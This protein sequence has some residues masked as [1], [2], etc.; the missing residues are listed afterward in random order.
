[1]SASVFEGVGDSR[2]PQL[3]RVEQSVRGRA[4]SRTYRRNMN[5]QTARK[6]YLERGIEQ[7]V[8]IAKEG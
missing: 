2:L 5:D 4:Q 8:C 6:D 1:M 7:V 3:P